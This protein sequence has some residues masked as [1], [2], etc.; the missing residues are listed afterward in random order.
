[1]APSPTGHLHVGTARAALYNYF[2]AKKH[3]GTFILRSEDTD[4]ERSTPEFEQEILDGLAWLGLSWESFYRQSERADIYKKYLEK[5]I[6]EDKAYISK[7][8]S[9]REPGT[10]IEV[11]R[12]RNSGTSVTFNDEVRGEVTFDTTELG[13]FVI[14]RAIDDALYHFTVVVDD[15]EMGVTHVIRGEDHIS[16]TPRQILIQEAIGAARPLYAHLP[17]LLA[18]DRSKLSKRHGAVSLGEYKNAGYLAS[19]LTNYL[20]LLG[21]N[22]GTDQEFFTFDALVEEF[23]LG[24]VQKGGAIFD[25]EKLKWFNKEHLNKMDGDAFYEYALPWILPMVENTPQYSEERL[26]KLMPTIRERIATGAEIHENAEAGEYDF[27]FTAPHPSLELL[28]WKNDMSAKDAL[29]RLRH[30][31]EILATLSDDA[32]HEEIKN[33]I[34]PYAEEVGKGEV[35]WPL[36]VALTG[37]ERSPDPFTVIH[38][39]GAGEAYKRVQQACD[40]IVS[41]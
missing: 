5:L 34:F 37:R 40:T 12:L 15:H 18:P 17:L 2:F 16:N 41:A 30:V 28:A 13:D 33:A 21:W 27:A 8:E 7:E 38:I 20:S 23:D 1:M 29:P 36:R 39:I 24:G 22:P 19:A 6:A 10:E 14:A 25:I 11:I 26:V 31:A 3:N 35:L 9:K 32:S 4:K